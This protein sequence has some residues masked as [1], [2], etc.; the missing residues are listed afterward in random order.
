M[1]IPYIFV[2]QFGD[3]AVTLLCETGLRTPVRTEF[4][5]HAEICMFDIT[6]CPVIPCLAIHVYSMQLRL[7]LPIP[8]TIIHALVLMSLTHTCW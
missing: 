3:F 4:H 2:S 1:R 6:M 7:D 8:N 5:Y